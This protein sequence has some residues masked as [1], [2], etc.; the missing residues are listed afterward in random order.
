[1]CLWHYLHSIYQ[2]G[3][4][5]SYHTFLIFWR[6]WTHISSWRAANLTKLCR[7]FWTPYRQMPGSCFSSGHE[8]FRSQSRAYCHGVVALSLIVSPFGTI[9]Y[10]CVDRIGLPR[11]AVWGCC[12]HGNERLL[13]SQWEFWSMR[14]VNWR[15]SH[16]SDAL[17]FVCDLTWRRKGFGDTSAHVWAPEW[18]GPSNRVWKSY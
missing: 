10:E 18:S 16:S 2:H 12:E 11:G 5:V 7:W 4:R 6:S 13:S 9:G 15:K 3:R 8:N 1:V 14:L 17:L